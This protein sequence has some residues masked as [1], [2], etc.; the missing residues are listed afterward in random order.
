VK[1]KYRG[2]MDF[3][4]VFNL[5]KWWGNARLKNIRFSGGEPTLI[6]Y[7]PLAVLLAVDEGVER[8]AISTNGSASPKLYKELV[9]CGMNDVSI[10]LD[11]CC[12]GTGDMMAGKSDVW[13]RVVDNITMLSE[14]TYTTVGVV[15]TPDNAS[16]L[17]GIIE[18][19]DSLDVSDIRIVPSAQWNE[20]KTL[21]LNIHPEILRRYPI[22]SYRIGNFLSGRNVR[23]MSKSDNPQCPLVLDDMA[24]IGKDHFPCI[25]Y[26]REGGHPIG[27]IYSH[28]IREERRRWFECRNVFED[29]IC[30][31]NCLDVCIDYNNKVK[32]LT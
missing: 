16:E 29:P 17:K 7:L 23:G 27:C 2:T 3:F 24:V 30:R 25:I 19:A 11:A 13:K 5:L 20:F 15:V 6:P 4:N 31:R 28:R 26:L 9:R 22:L 18:F 8:V 1:P 10:S 32:E 12:A 14:L 21:D